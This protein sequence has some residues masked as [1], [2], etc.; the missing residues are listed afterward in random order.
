M[1]LPLSPVTERPAAGRPIVA[2][3]GVG[4]TFERGTVALEA[5]DLEVRE[6]EF[7]SLLDEVIQEICTRAA[8]EK[9]IAQA[10]AASS[11]RSF[12]TMPSPGELPPAEPKRAKGFDMLQRKAAR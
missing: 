9:T 3:R 11:P 8:G 7:V 12:S 10:A 4:K 1:P 5:L 2:L 6:G